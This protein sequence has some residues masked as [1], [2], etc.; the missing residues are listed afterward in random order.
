VP[1]VPEAVL[2][3]HDRVDTAAERVGQRAGHLANRMRLTARDVVAAQATGRGPVGW[4][5]SASLP[6]AGDRLVGGVE[7]EQVGPGHVADVD[8]VTPLAAVLEYPRRDPVLQ[9][10]PEDGGDP[11]VGGVPRHPGAVD[12]VVPEPD[13]G[14]AGHPGPARRQVFLR[15]LAGGVGVARIERRVL[16][17]R[18]R[19]Q[20]LR[21]L[22]AARLEAPRVQVGRITGARPHAAVRGAVVGSLA[23]DDH[24][25]GHDQP[26]HAVPAHGLE[27]DRGP[28]DVHVRVDGQVR[29]VHAEADHGGLV[30]DRVDPGEGLAHRRRVTHVT[31]DQVVGQARRPAVV[32]GGGERIQAADLMACR[33]EDLSRDRPDEPGRA[34]NQNA[35]EF[36]K[37]RRTGPTIRQEQPSQLRKGVPATLRT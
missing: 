32:D 34:G 27:Q 11:G 7:G 17:D 26:R 16:G 9:A 18:G 3:G 24:R 2:P 25:R 29:Q 31:D 8:E 33:P 1:D 30:A 36:S 37:A 19:G 12:V 6:R 4:A 23:V 20:R 14:P 21:A 15:H 5:G 22:R 35:H 13:R 28:R 10:G